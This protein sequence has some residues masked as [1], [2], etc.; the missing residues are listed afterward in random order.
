[1]V[2]TPEE[3]V[4]QNFLR[5][6][7]DEKQFP[8]SLI[9]VEAGLKV[10]RRSKRTDAVVYNQSGEALVIIECKAPEVK[11]TQVV[12]DQIINYNMSLQVK[13]LMVTNGLSHICCQLNYHDFSVQYFKEVPDFESLVG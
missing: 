12:F 9:A 10:A 11:L 5:F 7:V 4:R 6:L 1:M 2:L 8:A 13:Y 3:W